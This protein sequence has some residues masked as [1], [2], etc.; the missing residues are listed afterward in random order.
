[1]TALPPAT[2]AATWQPKT[3]TPWS[4]KGLVFR[5]CGFRIWTLLEVYF[6][7]EVRIETVIIITVR[8]EGASS[9]A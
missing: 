2:H 6:N 9:K 1:M 8:R 4:C 7:K 5:V 3:K